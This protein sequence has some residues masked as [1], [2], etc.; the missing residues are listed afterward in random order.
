MVRVLNPYRGG[1]TTIK[2]VAC[3]AFNTQFRNLH[4]NLAQLVKGVVQLCVEHDGQVDHAAQS[5]IALTNWRDNHTSST[6]GRT[7][8]VVLQVMAVSYP[9]EQQATLRKCPS[10]CIRHG[11]LGSVPLSDKIVL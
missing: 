4:P 8:R 10:C 3:R 2:I 6:A 5:R 9:A 7:T 1:R 11:C